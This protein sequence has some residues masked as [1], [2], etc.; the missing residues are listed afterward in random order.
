MAKLSRVWSASFETATTR[1]TYVAIVRGQPAES[2]LTIDLPIGRHP[3]IPGLARI[4]H[5]TRQPSAQ[6]CQYSGEIRRLFPC[7]RS[8]SKPAGCTRFA[9]ISRPLAAHW[10]ATGLR[11]RTV[12]S[13]PAQARLQ[14]QG[15][16]TRTPTSRPSRTP[17][18][19]TDVDAPRGRQTTHHDRPLAEGLDRCLQ[20]PATI[21]I[22]VVVGTRCPAIQRD[23]AA[24]RD[25]ASILLVAARRR[26]PTGAFGIG[27]SGKMPPAE[28]RPP[29]DIPPRFS[30]PHAVPPCAQSEIRC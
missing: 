16:G 2:P 17:C 24:M 22:G 30:H 6:H 5:S 26:D 25:S 11:W 20:I 18:G 15:R 19:A 1:K 9:C 8:S 13:V 28:C 7:S 29:T 10:S 3:R 14:T 23:P 21:R 27:Q 4:D 12:A